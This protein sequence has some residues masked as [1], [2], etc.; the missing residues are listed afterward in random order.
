MILRLLFC[1]TYITCACT[2]FAQNP[3][4]RE[5]RG[6]WITTVSNLDWP[7]SKT[8]ST[9]AQK[10]QLIDI[11]DKHKE[12][13]L[14][15][16]FLQIR[17][18]GDAFYPSDLAPWSD[19]LTGL[20]GRAPQP[21]YDPLAFAITEAHKRG[22]EFH[23]W[24]NPYRSVGNINT[25]VL[26]DNHVAKKHPEWLLAFGNARILDPGL[27][28]VR[29]HVT[30]VV[31]E[32]VRRYDID[33]VHFDDFFYPYPSTGL[34]Y[35]DDS[36]FTLH[37]RGF[38]DRGNWR[39]DNVDLLIKTVSDSIKSVKPFVKFGISPFGIWQNKS[40][41]QPLGSDTRGLESYSEIYCDSK[42]WVQQGWIDYVTPQLYW[43]IGFSIADYGILLPWWV[44]NA[45][46]RHIYVG[47]GAYRIGADSNWN[48][49]EMPR[50]LRL[51]RQKAPAIQ[52]S[53][54]F[55]TG[56][57]TENV[58]GIRDSLMQNFYRKPALLP[59]MSWKPITALSSPTNV[60]AALNTEG[61]RLTWTRPSIGT[62]ELSKIRD[63]VIYRF[64]D[65]EVIDI[66][67]AEAIQFITPND[68]T[69][70]IDKNTNASGRRQ[71]T[72]VVTAFNRLYDESTP[73]SSASV[74]VS[75]IS[76]ISATEIVELSPVSPNPVREHATISYKLKKSGQVRL[77]LF[78]INGR[79]QLVLKNV[80]Q[81]IGD[82]T[83]DMEV[84]SL[85]N[86]IYFLRLNTEGVVVSRKIVVT[87]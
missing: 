56:N 40:T 61:V 28:D 11:L 23:A 10:Q 16:V 59:T 84:T 42:K 70:F 49:G 18:N 46:N 13:G 86:G 20:Q 3:P 38:S 54:F 72:Y 85:T 15:A 8:L 22:L 76:D 63:Y 82:Y 17:T 51:N 77:S 12:A 33:G 58:L 53:I 80:S 48:A 24:F 45:S 79:E 7:L 27:P 71:Y 21:L 39:R 14:N 32:V 6:A 57:L 43:Y 5:C 73:S 1:F 36:T 67:K 26:A 9:D 19:W 30:Q 47:Q 29:S 62:A 44:Q 64:L 31:M 41:A 4:K 35:N 83:F 74:I 34:S 65:N 68:T 55:R 37:N 81:T 50:Q 69:V 2:I 52:G 66:T 78:D 60:A 25:A 75:S 87:K